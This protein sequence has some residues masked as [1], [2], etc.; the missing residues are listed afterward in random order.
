MA[1]GVPTS[2]VPCHNLLWWE[3]PGWEQQAGWRLI[4]L[5]EERCIGVG[6]A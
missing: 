3:F 1:S 6:R 4:R 5:V 2:R